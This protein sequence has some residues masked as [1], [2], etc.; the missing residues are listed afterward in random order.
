MHQIGMSDNKPMAGAER[1]PEVKYSAAYP[2]GRERMLE[3]RYG[4]ARAKGVG[5]PERS[6]P[7]GPQGAARER[8]LEPRNGCARAKGVGLPERSEPE[9]PQGAARERIAI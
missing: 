6:E 3:P 2:T 4:C 5:L 9:G 1:V 8:M 7:E